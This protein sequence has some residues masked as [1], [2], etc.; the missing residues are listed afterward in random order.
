M[1]T[2]KVVLGMSLA[3]LFVCQCHATRLDETFTGRT[4]YVSV[5]APAGGDGSRE[6]PFNTIQTRATSTVALLSG[7]SM[8]VLPDL[9]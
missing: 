2:G 1:A 4:W 3:A 6:A 8:S 9:M 5:H 7:M